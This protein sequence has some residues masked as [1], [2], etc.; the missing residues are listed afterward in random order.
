MSTTGTETGGGKMIESGDAEVLDLLRGLPD[1][2][3]PHDRWSRAL[4]GEKV[5]GQDD[6]NHQLVAAG[7]DKST[8][9]TFTVDDSTFREAM[10]LAGH[11][12]LEAGMPDQHFLAR[13]RA[14]MDLDAREF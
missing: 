1:P 14:G 12:T 4:N 10:Q 11:R 9:T 13:E 2:P 3:T 8:A 6:P 7:F 5:G